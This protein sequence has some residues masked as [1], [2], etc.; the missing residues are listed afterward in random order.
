MALARDRNMATAKQ[1]LARAVAAERQKSRLTSRK[2]KIESKTAVREP[3]PADTDDNV[4]AI[5]PAKNARKADTGPARTDKVEKPA[6][7]VDTIESDVAPAG[8]LT[9]PPKHN[10]KAERN[11][12]QRER[13]ARLRKEREKAARLQAQRRMAPP[14]PSVR[15]YRAGEAPPRRETRFTDIWNEPRRR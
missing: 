2:D 11:R 14:P 13:E 15:Y 3:K 5:A 6:K 4:G 10:D 1:A 12:Q 9:K 7:H 8:R